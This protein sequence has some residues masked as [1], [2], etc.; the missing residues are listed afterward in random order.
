MG[1][2][3]AEPQAAEHLTLEAVHGLAEGGVLGLVEGRNRPPAMAASVSAAQAWASL[4]ASKVAVWV[5]KPFLRITARQAPERFSKLSIDD[6]CRCYGL[7]HQATSLG[8]YL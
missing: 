7:H 3:G 4:L 5:G 6:V 2:L 1:R 8:G